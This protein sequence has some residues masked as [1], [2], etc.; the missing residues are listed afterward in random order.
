MDAQAI[1]NR[2]LECTDAATDS[3]EVTKGSM[4]FALRGEN[5]NGNRFATQALKEGARYAV[6]DDPQ[7]A[8]G[9]QFLLVENVL[10]T[11]QQ[12]ANMHRQ[13]MPARVVAITGSNG[14]TTTRELIHHVLS[15]QF[16]CLASEKNYNNHIGVPIT[17][18]RLKHEHRFAVV[19]MG[20]NHPGEIQR[21]C[22]I[23]L[24]DYGIITNIGKAHLEGF[25]SFEGVK[26]AKNELYE[27]VCDKGGT[28]FYNP[29]HHVLCE[30][31]KDK[32]CPMYGYGSS[33]Q[34]YCSGHIA[35]R[36]PFLVIH[37]EGREYATRLLGDYNFEN[38]MAALCVGKFA[39]VKPEN[40]Q[41][42]LRNY[43]P[44]NNRSQVLQTN[45]NEVLL[46]AYNANPTSMQAA[47]ENFYRL[48][49][50]NKVLIL[51]DMFELGTYSQQE[52]NHI[53]E[54]LGEMGFHHVYLI[55]K[56]FFSQ[57]SANMKAFKNTTDFMDWLRNHPIHNCTILIKGSR[58][59]A[60]EKITELL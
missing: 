54:K 4:F 58:G 19:E 35:E 2:Y 29:N 25:G 40:R 41:R 43:T 27:H 38:V 47:I 12:L 16:T 51:G 28:I 7:Y 22:E 18:L 26:K 24:P 32:D 55:G 8:T 10:Q 3:R 6:V 21:L 30:L 13:N 60:L 11:L 14:K 42:A 23:A 49:R 39:G 36:T 59:L 46:D 44:K 34:A 5:F 52:H 56:H 57:A 15:S 50:T 9:E 48:P 20:A 37:S 33:T 53:V 31:L 45:T 1:Y 17:L